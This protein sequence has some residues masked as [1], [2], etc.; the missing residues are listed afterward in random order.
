MNIILTSEMY[1]SPNMQGSY[2][3]SFAED[4]VVCV[5]ES[6]QGHTV[7]SASIDLLR[8]HLSEIKNSSENTII[9]SIFPDTS[10]FALGI[11]RAENF[12][13]RSHGAGEVYLLRS[14]KYLR[15]LSGNRSAT[16]PIQPGDRFIFTTKILT[17]KISDPAVFQQPETHSVIQSLTQLSLNGS[18]VVADFKSQQ[19]VQA[20]PASPQPETPQGIQ[21]ETINSQDSHRR[22][23]FI[24]T[25]R[26]SLKAQPKQ[27][28]VTFALVVLIFVILLWSVGLGYQRRSE[29]KNASQIAVTKELIQQKLTQADEVS[30]LNP[31]RALILIDE[32]KKEYN[33][34]KK[35]IAHDRFATEIA[36]LERMIKIQ[37][38]QITHKE[39]KSADEFFDLALDQKDAQGSRVAVSGDSMAILGERQGVVYVFSLEK[40][41]LEKR[42]SST[43]KSARLVGINGEDIY[44]LGAAGLVQVQPDGS[45]KTV[46][47]KDPDWGT[48]ADFAFYNNNVYI[49]DGT[50]G[51]IYKYIAAEEGFGS[52]NTYVKDGNEGLLAG[53]TAIAIDSSV[54]VSVDDRIMKFTAG[55]RDTFTTVY[56]EDG[57]RIE[58]II[59]SEGL[60]KA[61]AWNKQNG[62]VYILGKNGTYE[63][64]VKSEKFSQG[65]D[66]AVYK[67]AAYVLVKDKIYRISLE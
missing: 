41:S 58:K 46:I 1:S 16:G 20:Q 37:E 60:E 5:I 34:L 22:F 63:R 45:T 61:Y 52:K 19:N 40:K 25:M 24:S 12:Y 2:N 55:S 7:I 49:L 47:A 23:A 51:Q 10:S 35:D 33:A 38:D 4:G 36:E 6:T 26:D 66:L 54:Y 53:A 67:N 64:Q 8:K 9:S 65:S 30:F 27:K 18:V 28:F 39:T 11:V 43:V 32:A 44:I 59:T 56:P 14:G 29:A 57:V 62:T 17:D 21:P 42:A 50:K 13:V 3:G 15:L 31:Q 48:V